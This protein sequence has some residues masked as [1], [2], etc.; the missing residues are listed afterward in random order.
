MSAPTLPPLSDIEIQRALG[1]LP[2]WTRKGDTIAKSY[3]FATFP[4]GVAFIAQV[5]DIAEQLQHHPDID[6]RYTRVQFCLSTHEAGG[7]TVRDIELAR[8]IE[9]L[10]NP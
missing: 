4:A 1:T 7:V 8:R 5:A 9:A 6:I 3:H 2:G 10:A